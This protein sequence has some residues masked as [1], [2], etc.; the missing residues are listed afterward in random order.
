MLQFSEKSIGKHTE[1]L[2]TYLKSTFTIDSVSTL[3]TVQTLLRCIFGTNVAN[4]VIISNDSSMTSNIV[5]S[6]TTGLFY[7]CFD[8]PY[9]ELV[10]TF[11]LARD[12]TSTPDRSESLLFNRPHSR[13][14]RRSSSKVERSTLSNY[15]RLF[16]PMVIRALKHYT[17]TSNIDQQSQ[18][19]QLLI[20][21][22]DLR[23]NYCLLDS[24]KI[25]VNY[26]LSQL[27]LIEEGQMHNAYLVIP[28]MFRFLVLLSHEKYHSKPIIDVPKILQRCEGLFAS[29]QN[30]EMFVMPAL[31]PVADDL[32]CS[33]SSSDPSSELEAQ[34]EVMLTMLIKLLPYSQ[35]RLS[36][37]KCVILQPNCI[38]MTGIYFWHVSN[39]N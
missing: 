29:G 34:R 7:P 33:R 9:N 20:Q 24:D 28:E 22:V 31:I 15:I 4:Q 38:Q 32:F 17:I 2:L 6:Q 39:H 21:L 13:S 11:H 18:V 30:A 10:H 19:L 25:F 16:E 1:E 8:Q 14:T 5:F 3:K 37:P 36:N 12:S 23:V 35:V 26:V 27:D